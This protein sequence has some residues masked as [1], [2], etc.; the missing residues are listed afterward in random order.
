LPIHCY[1]AAKIDGAG[2]FTVFYPDHAPPFEIA[3]SSA[4]TLFTAVG[5]W[6]QYMPSILYKPLEARDEIVP[7]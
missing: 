4:T 7:G 3:S 6:N 1:E 2:E 5:Y